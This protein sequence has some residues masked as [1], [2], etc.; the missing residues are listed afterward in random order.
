LLERITMNT[1][2]TQEKS[3]SLSGLLRVIGFM[4]VTMSGGSYGIAFSV[5]EELLRK[6]QAQYGVAAEQRLRDWQQ[7]IVRSEPGDDIE[8][9]VQVNGFVNRAH[10]I[11]KTLHWQRSEERVDPLQF[12]IHHAGDG[13][14]FAMTKLFTLHKMGIPLSKL[15]IG[16]V[17]A[18]GRYLPKRAQLPVAQTDSGQSHTVLAY[19][20][21]PDAEPLILDNLDKRIRVASQRPDLEPVY[22][23]E[24]REM[25]LPDTLLSSLPTEKPHYVVKWQNLLPNLKSVHY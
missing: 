25:L 10:Q 11:T 24:A 8:K 16:Y 12:L 17:R 7:I 3:L 14:G 13:Q 6:V 23:F 9:L 2:I 20:S 1:Y 22:L 15:R 4:A 21:T 5:P 19:F 18:V